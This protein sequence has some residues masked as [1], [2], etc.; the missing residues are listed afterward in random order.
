LKCA[1]AYPFKQ[2]TLEYTAI[3]AIRAIDSF[4]D[5]DLAGM[6]DSFD[7]AILNGSMIG[8]LIWRGSKGRKLNILQR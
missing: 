2:E 3:H 6:N 7:S 8:R 4:L 1:A 5:G